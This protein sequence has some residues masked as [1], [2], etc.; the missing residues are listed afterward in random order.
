MEAV[1]SRITQAHDTLGNTQKRTQYDAYL[2]EQ[3]RSRG[4]EEL[5]E[6]ALAEVRRAEARVE[7]EASDAAAAEAAASPAPSP[8][9]AAVAPG[10]AR[11]PSVPPPV[12]DVAIAARRDALARRL[13]GGRSRPSSGAQQPVNPSGGNGTT[14]SPP[15][16]SASD[17]MASLR[18][19]YEERKSQAKETQARA[20][21][22][23]GHAALAANDP[24]GAANAF[25]VALS[26]KPD[27]LELERLARETQAKADEM[28]ASTYQNQATYEEQ[29]GQWA[30]AAR[31]WARVCRVRPGDARAHERGAH[32]IVKAGGDLHEAGRLAQRACT[33][34]P[35]STAFRVTLANVYLA[36]GLTLNARRELETAAQQSPQDGTIQAMLKRI[37]K[38]G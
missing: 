7:K 14:S 5:L 36:A 32:A 19:R 23:K 15:R 25:R 31:S 37:G 30:E 11:A 26:L 20:Y 35:S 16:P 27:D 33:L 38:S 4:I 22:A 9:P 28:L 12:V 6:D 13:L 10:P 34:D 24:V 1:F 21:T 2:D 29:N 3:R 18:R 17:A 8:P